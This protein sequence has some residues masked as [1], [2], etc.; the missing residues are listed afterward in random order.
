MTHEDPDLAP[1]RLAIQASRDA[2]AAGNM[3]FGAALVKDGAVLDLAQ[4]NQ[5]TSGDCSGHAETVLVRQAQAAG[6]VATLRGATVYASGEPC[7]MC[8]GTM[9][10]AGVSRVVF[11]ASQ[12]QIGAVL[13]APLLPIGTA[14]VYAG[15]DPP[16][17]VRGGVLADEAVQVLR[18]AKAG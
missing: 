14:E 16:V 18:S 6:R 12:A 5:L 8:A 9:F 1:M 11:A 3:P 17:A 7:A 13:G 2:V 4:N 10:W 15:S